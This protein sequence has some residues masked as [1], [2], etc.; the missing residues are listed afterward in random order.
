MA[1]ILLTFA[2]LPHHGQWSPIDRWTRGAHNIDIVVLGPGTGGRTARQSC[3][4]L[5]RDRLSKVHFVD[6]PRYPL[7]IDRSK[8]TCGVPLTFDDGP[9]L[10]SRRAPMQPKTPKLLDGLLCVL[11]FD[12][13]ELDLLTCGR[14]N[15][16]R[17]VSFCDVELLL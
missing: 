5:L 16:T 10:P 17:P 2:L 4:Q 8:L 3:L 12:K 11:A 7:A 13:G 6:L 14:V 15:E 9:D 1:I